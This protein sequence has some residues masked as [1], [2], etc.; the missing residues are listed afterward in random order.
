MIRPA[1]LVA[2]LLALVLVVSGSL[3]PCSAADPPGDGASGWTVLFDG[4]DLSAWQN[5]GGGPPG[6]GWVIE[7][8]ALVRQPGAGYI[9]TKQRFG[10]FVLDLEFKTEGN[11]GVFFRTDNPKD[12][13]QTGFEMQIERKGAPG[14]KGSL[15]A[16]YDCLAPCKEVGKPG[17]WNRVVITAVDNKITVEI[18]DEQVIEM[19][20][21]EWTEPHLNPDGSRNKFR[22]ALKDFKREGH[23]GFQDHGAS[24]AYRNVKIKTIH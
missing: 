10:D 19:D 24:V 8:G 7:D 6:S 17:Q 21:D 5:A 4:Q 13:V 11:S 9:W 2:C 15:G 1:P 16:I 23:I 22:T 12:P 20:L 14:R 3:R 18:N